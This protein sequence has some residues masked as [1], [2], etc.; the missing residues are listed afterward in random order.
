MKS[1]PAK[2]YWAWKFEDNFWDVNWERIITRKFIGGSFVNYVTFKNCIKAFHLRIFLAKVMK[3][4]TILLKFYT[5]HNFRKS[6]KNKP[7]I[8]PNNKVLKNLPHINFTTQ[9]HL[10]AIMTRSLESTSENSLIGTLKSCR[11]SPLK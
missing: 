2:F 3:S 4:K 11:V 5:W 10:T 1:F 9:K 7:V 8:D 6:P